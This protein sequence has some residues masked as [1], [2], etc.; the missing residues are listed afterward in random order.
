MYNVAEPD[1]PLAHHENAA[2][3]EDKKQK[4]FSLLGI[5]IYYYV[6]KILFFY[7]QIGCIPTDV[8]RDYSFA[9]VSV[10]SCVDLGSG[11]DYRCIVTLVSA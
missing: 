5:E 1:I 9:C 2:N 11:V 3:L 6:K 8:H 4:Q 10:C 7:P